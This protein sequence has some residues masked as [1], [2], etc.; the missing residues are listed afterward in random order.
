VP[1]FLEL[2]SRIVGSDEMGFSE[3]AARTTSDTAISRF[4]PATQF[5]FEW[6]IG[7]ARTV[8]SARP[9]LL[10]A[11]ARWRA[12]CFVETDCEAGR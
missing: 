4:F 5:S 12:A 1:L 7:T 9:G 8:R 3:H 6:G 10:Q 2:A 11:P